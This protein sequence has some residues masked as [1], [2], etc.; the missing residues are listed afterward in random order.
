MEWYPGF[1]EAMVVS[2]ALLVM[3]VSLAGLI[4]PVFPG[5]VVIWLV[6]L[7]YGLF[8][9]FGT[10]GGV[11][12]GVLTLLMIFGAVVD[13]VLMGAKAREKGASWVS[14]G[15]ALLAGVVGTFAFPPIGGLIAAP[16]LL[17]V[18]ELRRLG[19]KQ[20]ALE[21]VKALLIGWG[22]AFAARFGIGLVMIG[23]W[24]IWAASS[25]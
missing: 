6:A 12:F 1:L 4:I 22:W 13:N 19:D 5:L 14:I 24:G 17:Y 18:L 20:Q 16:L 2:G 21:V 9:G 8:S 10:V 25:A 3:L 15:L 23:L 7:V 11:I